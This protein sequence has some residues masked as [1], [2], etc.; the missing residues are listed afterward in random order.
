MRLAILVVAAVLA[1]VAHA[2][3]VAPEPPRPAPPA[4]AGSVGALPLSAMPPPTKIEINADVPREVAVRCLVLR[5][6]QMQMLQT[7]DRIA[8]YT[9]ARGAFLAWVSRTEDRGQER[10][11]N[12]MPVI[13]P[14][15]RRKN[16]A[17]QGAV[18]SEFR[19]TPEY[20]ADPLGTI[21]TLAVASCQPFETTSP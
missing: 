1:G 14:E 7:T 20:K 18:I 11:P 19:D 15:S 9:Y 5:S 13:N 12:G 16:Q 4:P 21:T 3:V 10:L 8:D 6:H 2:Q 17:E